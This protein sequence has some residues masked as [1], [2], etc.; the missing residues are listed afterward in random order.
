MQ[1]DS[2]LAVNYPA[3]GMGIKRGDGFQAIR[4][5]GGGRCVALHLPVIGIVDINAAASSATRRR[6]DEEQHDD[7]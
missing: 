6:N 4:E 2:A 5:K 3:R 1:W 7:G